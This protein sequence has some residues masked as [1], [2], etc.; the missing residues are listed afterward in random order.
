M[1]LQKMAGFE[2]SP[3][4]SNGVMV[5][6]ERRPEK[7]AGDQGRGWGNVLEPIRIAEA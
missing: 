3:K 4:R 5:G 1:S 6:T 2:Q 7:R